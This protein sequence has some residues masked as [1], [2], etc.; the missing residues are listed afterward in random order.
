MDPRY[1]PNDSR[2]YGHSNR[3]R[4]YQE[5][6]EQYWGPEHDSQYEDPSLSGSAI[7]PDLEYQSGTRPTILPPGTSVSAYGGY[8]Q[9][10]YSSYGSSSSPS[11]QPYPDQPPS[12]REPYD[13][14]AYDYAG[15][16]AASSYSYDYDFGGDEVQSPE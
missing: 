9:V 6:Q 15:Q 2:H 8:R 5:G 11:Q 3:D 1:S 4:A 7:D 16:D 13:Y 10:A 14:R 12:G